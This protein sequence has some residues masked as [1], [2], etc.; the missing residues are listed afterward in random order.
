MLVNLY[1]I[2]IFFYIEFISNIK[3]IIMIDDVVR[4]IIMEKYNYFRDWM[5]VK[6][7]NMIYY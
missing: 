4:V 6:I 5:K 7:Y 1:I 3:W 2:F